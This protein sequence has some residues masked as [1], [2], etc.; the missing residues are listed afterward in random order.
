MKKVMDDG[1]VVTISATK[2]EFAR[3]GMF[4]EWIIDSQHDMDTALISLQ[5]HEII[6]Y[7]T[8]WSDFICKE[9]LED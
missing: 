3:L 6:P 4:L 1:D 8:A 2:A 5:E 7:V 9:T